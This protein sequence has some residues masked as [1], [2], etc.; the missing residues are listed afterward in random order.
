MSNALDTARRVMWLLGLYH[1]KRFPKYATFKIRGAATVTMTALFPILI[2]VQIVLSNTE[3]ATI[4]KQLSFFFVFTWVILRILLYLKALPKQRAVEDLLEGDI[5]NMQN[6]R[7]DRFI[8]SVWTIQK[9][10]LR[11]YIPLCVMTAAFFALPPV[12]I[13]Q[14]ANI[15]IWTPL[16]GRKEDVVIYVFECCYILLQGVLY[17]IMDCIFVGFATI[18]TAQIGIL[19][20]NLEHSTDRDSKE[21]YPVQERKIQNR[22]RTCIIHHNAILE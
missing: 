20:S 5:F 18:I 22:L 21:E 16:H 17:P 6:E 7:L 10:L 9:Y 19:K 4:T 3:F 14:F 2:L 12:V 11:S 13:H 1:G 8:A 15:P